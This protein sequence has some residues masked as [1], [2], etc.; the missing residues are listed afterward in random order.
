MYRTAFYVRQS[1]E[2]VDNP[3]QSVQNQ[4]KLLWDFVRNKEEFDVVGIYEDIWSGA[5][6]SRPDF[7]RLVSDINDGKIDC[8]MVKDLSRLGR[9][10]IETGEHLEQIFPMH[11][12]RF[13]S[14][15]DHFDTN[16]YN[17]GESMI[18]SLKNILNDLQLRML[19][20]NIRKTTYIKM[21]RGDYPSGGGP[22]GY[23]RSKTNPAQLI[24]DWNTAPI[25]KKIFQ[26]KLDGKST[27]G[28]AKELTNLG[29]PTPMQYWRSVGRLK[30]DNR[31]TSGSK[32]SHITV[33][34]ILRNPY[35]TG[36]CVNGRYKR[37]K[38]NEK[39]RKTDVSYSN[40]WIITPNTHEAII[41]EEMFKSV[42]KILEKSVQKRRA[43][44]AA[45]PAMPNPF[46][47]IVYCAICGKK[48]VRK[49]IRDHY[50][51][52]CDHVHITESDLSDLTVAALNNYL[53]R[54][55][56]RTY[57]TKDSLPVPS[58][59]DSEYKKNKIQLYENYKNGDISKM[60]YLQEKLKLDEK[61]EQIKEE[62]KKKTASMDASFSCKPSQN[63]PKKDVL[64]NIIKKISIEDT[65]N[66]EFFFY[67]LPGTT[68]DFSSH[69]SM[70]RRPTILG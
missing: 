25:V 42:Q 10:Y 8:V 22:Y 16:D 37:D 23:M 45:N 61:L 33:N 65:D 70:Q 18:I 64:A 29:V 68:T 60:T 47:N 32:W 12:V 1:K 49:K 36:N 58:I 6:F 13:I 40:E 19:S 39:S 31:G 5:T 55:H 57:V 38:I 52:R 67:P 17:N 30:S 59:S 3:A 7:L 50:L 69:W 11:H 26:M 15:N 54:V 27:L 35:Y 62:E 44:V 43:S 9:N 28:I 51:F 63:L 41:D 48:L 14:V 20:Q 24:V 2:N 46:P 21:E 66:A 53:R 34:D 4:Q 56:R